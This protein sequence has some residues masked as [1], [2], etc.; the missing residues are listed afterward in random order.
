LDS[1]KSWFTLHAGAVLLSALSRDIPFAVISGCAT[2]LLIR[3]LW[4][5]ALLSQTAQL[6]RQMQLA[7][8]EL[9]PMAEAQAEAGQHVAALQAELAAA[10]DQAAAAGSALEAAARDASQAR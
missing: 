4:V 5:C 6:Q 7:E 1:G 2:G 10:H 8:S 9:S 3:G